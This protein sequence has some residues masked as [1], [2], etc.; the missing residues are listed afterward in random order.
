MLSIYSNSF[1]GLNKFVLF[2]YLK[3]EYRR[4]ILPDPLRRYHEVATKVP[5]QS[6]SKHILLTAAGKLV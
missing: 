1:N 3:F 5:R 6:A 4:F 2:V